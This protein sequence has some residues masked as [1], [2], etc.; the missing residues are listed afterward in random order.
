MKKIIIMA[1]AVML[2]S[3]QQAVLDTDNGDTTQ[4]NLTLIFNTSGA[5]TRANT[6]GATR[7]TTDPATA[8]T[9]LNVMLFTEDGTKYFDK[10]RTQYSTDEDFCQMSLTL[11]AGEYTVVAVGHSSAKSAT[12]KSPEQVQFT[13]SDGQ[14]LTDTFSYC[15][16]VSVG[17]TPAQQS[18]TMSRMV[19]MVRFCFT[20]DEIPA[21]LATMK[22]D[23]TGG[24]ANFNPT[25]SQ[26]I[27]KS[28]QSESRTVSAND[29]YRIYTFPY[30]S[31]T[32][33][34]QVTM[35]ALTADGTVITR[36]T[37]DSIPVTR[38]RITTYTGKLFGEGGG[39]VSQ[40]GF[41]FTVDGEWEGDDQHTF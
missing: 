32:G 5:A 15:G 22:F 8:F 19:A 1:A 3:C 26:G 21:Q 23:Y 9:K 6:V 16:T 40:S 28:K 13:A 2:A 38:N 35:S 29:E 34:L 36:R 7:A 20:D 37:L 18:L 4:G 27:T 11:P 41:T 39:T 25:T 31:S 24:S 12:I 33:T 30:Q 14:K 17:D 10:V